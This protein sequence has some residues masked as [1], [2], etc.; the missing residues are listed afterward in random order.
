[1]IFHTK[2]ILCSWDVQKFIL[3]KLFLKKYTKV[4]ENFFRLDFLFI[5]TFKLKLKP[6]IK[7]YF[8]TMKNIF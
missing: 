1:M 3:Y 8:I 6:N 7:V 2:I 4:I 5:N